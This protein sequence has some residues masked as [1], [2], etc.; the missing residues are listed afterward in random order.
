MAPRIVVSLT[1]SSTRVSLLS[2]TI[3]NGDDTAKDCKTIIRGS[4]D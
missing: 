1:A 4:T 3:H 2:S